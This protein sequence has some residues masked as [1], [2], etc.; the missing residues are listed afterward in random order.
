MKTFSQFINES[1]VDPSS[2]EFQKY[3][4]I[5]AGFLQEEESVDYLFD[6]PQAYYFTFKETI[7][8]KNIMVDG[9][10]HRAYENKH[11][12]QDSEFNLGEIT[13]TSSTLAWFPIGTTFTLEYAMFGD[14][15]IKGDEFDLEL[16]QQ[17]EDAFL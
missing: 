17:I 4:V 2:D 3:L 13:K 16:Y 7:T 5:L 8:P 12:F 6:D 9:R 10:K 11:W 15:Y 14:R 1:V